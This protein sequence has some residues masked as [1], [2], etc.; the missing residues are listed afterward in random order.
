MKSLKY[1]TLLFFALAAIG[2][3]FPSAYQA[4]NTWKVLPDDYRYG[5]L[6]RLS[7]L[8]QFKEIQ[9]KCPHPV[10]TQKQN[11][12]LYTIGDSFLEKERI[13]SLD[14]TV[15][16]Y[17][18][19]KRE[20]K[21]QIVLD[22]SLENVLL[23]ECVERHAREYF[24]KEITDYEVVKSIQPQIEIKSP[25]KKSIISS[26]FKTNSDIETCFGLGQIEQRFENVFFNFNILLFF[27]E[28]KASL[29]YNLFNRTTGNATV[30]ENGEHLFYHLDTD[31]TKTLN[32]SFSYLSDNEV[33]A[34]VLNID[35]SVEKY[36]KS[37][38][39]KVYLCIIPNKAS[40][41]EPKRGKYNELISRIQTNK[42]LQ[43]SYI[44]IYSVYKNS[45]QN[46]YA[47]SDSHWN[48]EG[49]RLWLELVNNEL[50]K[51][52]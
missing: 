10:F 30:S 29:V 11:I 46:V 36:K 22:T 3:I 16:K 9:S 25:E 18:Y 31:T 8:P 41:L 20:A 37:G 27:K 24:A 50:N 21:E 14:F 4:L 39:K 38:F 42:K 33:D 40:I 7:N 49:R 19:I 43:A 23:I 6:Y 44:D 12:A 52:P 26:L 34:M 1:F 28:L 35:K 2:A 47:L 32:A 13:D 51:K 48:C 15:E 17:H 45:S 5:D